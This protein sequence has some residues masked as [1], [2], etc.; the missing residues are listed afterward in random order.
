MEALRLPCPACARKV[1]MVTNAQAIRI[2]EVDSLTL[3]QLVAD[4]QVHSVQTVSGNTWVCKESLFA[5]K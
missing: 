5:N 2:L 1:E 3:G 4:S